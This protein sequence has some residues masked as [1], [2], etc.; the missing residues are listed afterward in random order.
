MGLNRIQEKP[1]RLS[2]AEF[3][4]VP[5]TLESPKRLTNA[6]FFGLVPVAP[7]STALPI[8]QDTQLTP[9]IGAEPKPSGGTVESLLGIASNIPFISKV[10]GLRKKFEEARESA[11]GAFKFGEVGGMLATGA[12]SLAGAKALLKFTPKVISSIAKRAIP[13]IAKNKKAQVILA[14]AGVDVAEGAIADG[15][16]NAIQGELPNAKDLAIFAAVDAALPTVFKVAGKVTKKLRPTKESIPEAKKIIPGSQVT[17]QTPVK[18]GTESQR[19]V[20]K[21]VSTGDAI[22]VSQAPPKIPDIKEADDI[23]SPEF[24]RAAKA[25]MTR[26]REIL[27]LDT[28]SSPE[29]VTF[30][31]TLKS[32]KAKGF[33]KVE[34]TDALADEVLGRFKKNKLGLLTEEV[35]ATPRAFNPEETAGMVLRAVELKNTHK[36]LNKAASKLPDNAPDTAILAAMERI[37]EEFDRISEALRRSGTESG[38][39]LVAHKLTLNQDFDL[40]SIRNRAQ[41]AKKE[42]KKGAVLTD[43][44]NA[45]FKELTDKL[46]KRDEEL[47]EALRRNN[48]R[49]AN[50]LLLKGAKKFE[51]MTPIEKRQA[52]DNAFEKAKKLIKE[53][54][55]ISG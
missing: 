5:D 35:K 46:A 33:D 15:L 25:D 48:K 40:V 55:V 47:A 34:K 41:I 18:S 52:F 21:P 45:K 12:G 16:F 51:K 8:S 24:T 11:P 36:A 1:K 26:D 30:E 9:V 19:I 28:L 22:K 4:G 14:R 49:S 29:T 13:K 42:S 7:E 27:N 38:R 10:P 32:A 54:C 3:F 39:N 6:E 17:K 2:N 44:E 23:L 43:K 53:G 31:A 20:S 50:V 37:Q